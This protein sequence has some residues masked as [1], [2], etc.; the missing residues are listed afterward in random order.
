MPVATETVAKVRFAGQSQLDVLYQYKSI[1]GRPVSVAAR[2]CSLEQRRN[3][4]P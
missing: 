3:P 1:N 2:S 4:L